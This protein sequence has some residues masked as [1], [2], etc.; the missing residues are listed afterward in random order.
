LDELKSEKSN[1]QGLQKSNLEV[2]RV[3]FLISPTIE[4]IRTKDIEFKLRSPPS[5]ELFLS[6]L[7]MEIRIKE[8]EAS[9]KQ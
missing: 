1:H 5:F 2:G 3:F 4:S 7:G 6:P 9:Y 8:L